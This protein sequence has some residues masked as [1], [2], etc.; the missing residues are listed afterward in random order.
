[1]RKKERCKV[2]MTFGEGETFDVTD[3]FNLSKKEQAAWIDKYLREKNRHHVAKRHEP[4]INRC[5]EEE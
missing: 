1:M 3:F 5:D 2:T 4:E